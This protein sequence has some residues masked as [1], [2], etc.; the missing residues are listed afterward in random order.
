MTAGKI[1][2]TGSTNPPHLTNNAEYSIVAVSPQGGTGAGAYVAIVD[3]GGQ[4]YSVDTTSPNFTVTAL[5][6]PG[7]LI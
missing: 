6:A 1:Q 5:Y 2:Y 3:D 7:E 4:L